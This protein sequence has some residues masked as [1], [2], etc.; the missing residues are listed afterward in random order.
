MA[1]LSKD[2]NEHELDIVDLDGSDDELLDYGNN[3][4]E[5]QSEQDY[6]YNESTEDYPQA[7]TSKVNL[8]KDY[9]D[10]SDK[11]VKTNDRSDKLK[12]YILY[13]ITD[14]THH[15]MLSYF[16]YYGSKVTKIYDNLNEAKDEL[17]MQI[18]PCKI[19]VIDSGTGKFTG[20]SARKSLMDLLSISD[21]E[22]RITIFYTDSIIKSEANNTEGVE[23][24]DITWHKYKTM[25]G[26]L[27]LLL[28]NLKKENYVYELEDEEVIDKSDEILEF[29]GG[30]VRNYK[31]QDIG[32]SI[33]SVEE[34]I[35]HEGS[36]IS[37]EESID[38]YKIRV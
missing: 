1:N 26:V 10:Y 7:E 4:S 16:R 2:Y 34:I 23:S 11:D 19:V 33:L 12:N 22:N 5:V 37:A 17:L 24:K 25:S 36:N 15:G 3:I 38:G 20:M 32:M 6:D 28:Q 30:T 31:E 9:D 27:A 13:I 8:S 29:T 35:M 21:E 14:K 18:E